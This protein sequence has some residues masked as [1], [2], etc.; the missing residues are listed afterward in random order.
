MTRPTVL[1]YLEQSR[2]NIIVV[3]LLAFTDKGT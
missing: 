1:Q 2:Y 3:A